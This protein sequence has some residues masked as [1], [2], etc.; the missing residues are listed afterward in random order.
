MNRIL[1]IT[2]EG[3]Q[4]GDYSQFMESVMQYVDHYADAKLKNFR[5]ETNKYETTLFFE[6]QEAIQKDVAEMIVESLEIELMDAYVVNF[7]TRFPA[8]I[9]PQ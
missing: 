2:H 8:R 3:P 6:F 5:L 4:R 9:I 1:Q 7:V